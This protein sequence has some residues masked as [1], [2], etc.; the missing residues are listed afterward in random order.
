M[1][2]FARSRSALFL[3]VGFGT[4]VVVSLVFAADK[5]DAQV[6]QIVRD[7]RILPSHAAARPASLNETIQQGTGVRT[8]SESRAELTFSDQSLT[9]LGANTVFSF[10]QGARDLNLTSGAVL[11]CVPPEAGSVRLSTPAVSAAIS[12]GI[13]MAETHKDSW[14]KIIIVEGQ[15]VV[16]LKGSGETLT[17]HAGDLIALPPG[18][19]HFTKVQHI[20]L[21]KLVGKSLLVRFAKLPNWVWVLI[22][23]EIKTQQN[24]PP[25]PGGLKDPMGLDSIDQRAATIPQ[26]TPRP[27]PR[28]PG[29]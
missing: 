15:G 20:S 8:G 27:P 17:L 2:N 21:K 24:S 18:A 6:T 25:P 11:I 22:Q 9:R 28:P 29:R 4:L 26:A 3:A 14:V 5:R 12:G 10:D 7:V 19:K 16:T 23:H 13:A 1:K